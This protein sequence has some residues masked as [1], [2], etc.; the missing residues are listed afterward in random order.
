[1][2]KIILILS[3]FVA[4]SYISLAVCKLPAGVTTTP[5]WQEGY[6][7][8]KVYYVAG[9]D[10]CWAEYS[11]C[12][13]ILPN[14]DKE[15]ALGDIVLGDDCS[16]WEDIWGLCDCKDEYY[17]KQELIM[18]YAIGAIAVTYDRFN[19]G[20]LVYCDA[21]GNPPANAPHVFKV[22][23]SKCRTVPFF[24]FVEKE[25]QQVTKTCTS[26]GYCKYEYKYCY[27]IGTNGIATATYSKTIYEGQSSQ[28][29]NH[30]EVY[31]GLIKDCYPS[32]CYPNKLIKKMISIDDIKD[33]TTSEDYFISPLNNF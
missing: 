17:A 2:K 20:E 23:T 12:F 6:P 5:A 26:S 11:W 9:D 7:K 19:I 18:D 32:D 13:R 14:G 22:Y 16:W 25:G 4:F 8:M 24:D 15:I 30:E 29:P 27:R 28:C 31:P 1:M 3:L 33:Y 10:K 21:N